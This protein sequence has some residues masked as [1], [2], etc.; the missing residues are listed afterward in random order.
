VNV[1]IVWRIYY[2]F[3][4]EW[5]T[6]HEIFADETDAGLCQI[7]LTEANKDEQVSYYVAPWSVK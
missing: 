7:E 2:D 3:C 1:F 6:I 4:D 5:N